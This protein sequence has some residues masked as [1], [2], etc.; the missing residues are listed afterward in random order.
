MRLTFAVVTHRSTIRVFKVIRHM[1]RL[2]PFTGVSGRL[3][4]LM[5]YKDRFAKTLARVAERRL[6]YDELTGKTPSS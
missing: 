3:V 4:Y 5:V 6:T 2:S 1:S